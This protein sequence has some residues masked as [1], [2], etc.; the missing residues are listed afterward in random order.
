MGHCLS[1]LEPCDIE[2]LQR[3]NTVRVLVLHPHKDDAATMG[4]KNPVVLNL[5]KLAKAHL[6]DF[7][8]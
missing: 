6:F 1:F 2:A 3:F 7:V 5:E 4:G 8:L